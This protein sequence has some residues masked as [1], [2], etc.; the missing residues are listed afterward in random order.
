MLNADCFFKKISEF[1]KEQEAKFKKTGKKVI[2]MKDEPSYGTK[3]YEALKELVDFTGYEAQGFDKEKFNTECNTTC[4][5]FAF[6]IGPTGQTKPVCLNKE[7]FQRSLRKAKAIERRGTALPKTE[8]PEKDASIQYEARQKA[9]RV[10]F[11]KREF[12]IKGMKGN[13][14]DVQINRLLLHQL[15]QSESGNGESISLLLKTGKKKSNWEVRSLELLN[16][17]TN[18]KLIELVKEVILNRLNNY[19]IE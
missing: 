11:F 18:G 1:Q 7:C 6:I 19:T 10:D 17:F 2:V 13:A 14:K 16:E 5:T 9:N 15:F 12:F 8:D 4:P 3:E